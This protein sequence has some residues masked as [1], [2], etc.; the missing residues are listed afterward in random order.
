MLAVFLGRVPCVI[1]SRVRPTDEFRVMQ[2][3]QSGQ[4]AIHASHTPKQN[5][6]RRHPKPAGEADHVENGGRPAAVL[7]LRDG[8]WV[9]PLQP[10]ELGAI[11]DDQLARP[12]DAIADL[13]LN[14]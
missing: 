3:Q 2:R 10:G 11:G 12:S 5:I 13:A 1:G 4:L 6:I 7:D 8:R 9:D 14:I